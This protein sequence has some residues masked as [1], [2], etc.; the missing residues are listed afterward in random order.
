MEF[1]KKIIKTTEEIF[2]TMIF[3]EISPGEPLADE[4]REISCHVSAMIGL[5][6][7]FSGMLSIHCP[8]PVGLAITG[9]MLGMDLEEISADV[10]DALGEIANMMA[11]GLKEAFA[12]ENIALEI[13]I[14]TAISGKS[15]TISSP[16]GS[17]RVIIPFKVEQGQFFVEM[18]YSLN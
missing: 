2:N 10:K 17:G 11:G 5:T 13:A 15:Y 16:S 6:G 12:A 9:A 8:G 7:D 4:K 18:K 14:P 3:M 1:A